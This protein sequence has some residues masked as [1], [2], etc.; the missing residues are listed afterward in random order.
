M[1][2]CLRVSPD[3]RFVRGPTQYI[4]PYLYR[5]LVHLP[6]RRQR[7][8]SVAADEAR[9]GRG[10]GHRE[11]AETGGLADRGVAEVGGGVGC[12]V[13]GEVQ[14]VHDLGRRREPLAAGARHP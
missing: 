9:D 7:G 2:V 3:I 11:T 10:R 6:R 12:R 5:D 8:P 4:Q 1:S 13:P 14:P